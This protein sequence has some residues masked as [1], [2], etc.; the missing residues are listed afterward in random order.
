MFSKFFKERR[1]IDYSFDGSL[2]TP[3]E[4]RDRTPTAHYVGYQEVRK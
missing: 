2:L 3:G 4:Q 1:P